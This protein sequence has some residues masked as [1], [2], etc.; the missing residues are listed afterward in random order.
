YVSAGLHDSRVSYWEPA[1]WVAKQRT[2]THQ[3]RVLVLKTNMGAG[4]MGQSGRFDRLNEL[5]AE[6]AFTLKA[7][8]L[9]NDKL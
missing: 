4:H 1:K 9:A 5:A 6:Y 3:D 8:G 7:F 2:L